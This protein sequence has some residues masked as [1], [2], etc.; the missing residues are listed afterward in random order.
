MMGIEDE[1][2]ILRDSS[3]S[4]GDWMYWGGRGRGRG[5]E[6]SAVGQRRR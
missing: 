5:S 3:R 2:V 6:G 1:G 4:S